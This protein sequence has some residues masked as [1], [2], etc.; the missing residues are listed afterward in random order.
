V[1]VHVDVTTDGGALAESYDTLLR[2]S[3][4]GIASLSVPFDPTKLGGSLAV[5]S[6]NPRAKLVQLGL[7]ATLTAAGMAGGIRG[8]EQTDSGSGNSAASSVSGAVLAVWPDSAVCQ[9]LTGDGGGLGVAIEQTVLGVSGTETLA[10]V[11]TPAPASVTWL[12]GTNTKLSLEIESEGDGCFRVRNDLPV[13]IG[14]GAGITY[15][16]TIHAKSEDGRLD[17]SYAGAVA[18]SGSGSERSVTASA[19]L[20]LSVDD[21]A[22]SGFMG[23]NVPSGS[24]ALSL[25][26]T[27]TLAPGDS[28]G[29]IRLVAVTNPPCLTS[30]E[31]PKPTPD[32]G[33]SAPACSG[34]TLTP[35]E[36]ATWTN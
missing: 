23:V 26:V 27:S 20:D 5:S 34:S 1:E 22:K 3:V 35:L 21:V 25:Q 16:V 17:G 12:D 31:P 9:A 10:S 30:P 15:P 6:S 2:T 36:M 18:V 13:D 14:G 11:A 29:A 4:P 7:E 19:W 33:M 32:G 24:D 8:L 28:S